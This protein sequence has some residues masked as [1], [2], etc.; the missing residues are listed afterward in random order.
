MRSSTVRR[1][2]LY[3]LVVLLWAG[4]AAPSRADEPYTE[5]HL[6]AAKTFWATI[7]MRLRQGMPGSELLEKT[8]LC[9]SEY[10][11]CYEARATEQIDGSPRTLQWAARIDHDPRWE[12][13]T[14]YP[15][16]ERARQ[17]WVARDPE[18]GGEIFYRTRKSGRRELTKV[19][20]RMVR[21][22][23]RM[24]L[25][26]T[27]EAFEP[28]QQLIDRALRRWRFMVQAAV[29]YGVFKG[30]PIE[31]EPLAG[32]QAGAT[33]TS[34]AIARHITRFDSPSV[35]PMKIRA[36]PDGLEPGERYVVDIEMRPE[37]RRFVR[38]EGPGLSATPVG[39][40]LE[41]TEDEAEVELHFEPDALSRERPNI[42]RL[43][44]IQGDRNAEI[45]VDVDDW[46]PIITRFNVTSDSGGRPP[47]ANESGASSYGDG[48]EDFATEYE[49]VGE[50]IESWLKFL[51]TVQTRPRGRPHFAADPVVNGWRRGVLD[52]G[53]G[54]QE[55][56][57]GFY[58]SEQT[59]PTHLHHG[60]FKQGARLA[61][62]LDLLLAERPTF[63]TQPGEPQVGDD[64]FDD[65]KFFRDLAKLMQVDADIP[66][67]I[68]NREHYHF[69]EF[70]LSIHEVDPEAEDWRRDATFEPIS[71]FLLQGRGAISEYIPIPAV[72]SPDGW[73]S[74]PSRLHWVA[75]RAGIY[76]IRLQARVR[77]EGT[78]GRIEDL[79][80]EVNVAIRVRIVP[81]SFS[82]RTLEWSTARHVPMARPGD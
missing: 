10:V 75:H 1:P 40:Q 21:D 23:V 3:A 22:D 42:G 15:L 80:R 48:M 64:D 53:A 7:S 55:D 33:L 65:D 34:G 51:P 18:T 77:R 13:L 4:L 12:G 28:K 32:D 20:F 11:Y 76:E 57:N 82:Q 19:D 54:P 52:G 39:Y 36:R 61:I 44:F 31:L 41:A 50:M 43:K 62:N 45:A 27:R 29:H 30:R 63:E 35:L 71:G 66:T 58:V 38:L 70:R 2:I 17:I 25:A 26:V 73:F 74:V 8:L 56:P 68:E 6:R 46:Q 16:D 81:T 79:E 59:G 24:T 72:E 49:N 14:E 9:E 60:T 47:I 37:T 67:R 78:S 5:R 69:E